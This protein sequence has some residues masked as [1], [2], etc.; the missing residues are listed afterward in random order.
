L[1][2]EV[3][4]KVQIKGTAAGTD[5]DRYPLLLSVRDRSARL[6]IQVGSDSTALINDNV[7]ATWDT[8]GLSG[9]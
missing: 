4:G 7:L 8:T 1:F 9:L 2:T 5:F 6:G 3:N